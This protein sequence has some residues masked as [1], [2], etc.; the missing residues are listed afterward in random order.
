ML[1]LLPVGRFHFDNL[2]HG[3]FVNWRFSWTM[4]RSP[5]D[6]LLTP[7]CAFREGSLRPCCNRCPS[8]TCVGF[9][10]GKSQG[11][12]SCRIPCVSHAIFLSHPVVP[13]S[14]RIAL[15]PRSTMLRLH[16]PRCFVSTVHD[17]LSP[18][19]LILCLH[20]PRCFVSTVHD[21][22]SPHT[23]IRCLHTP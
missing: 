14:C 22:L 12:H 10:G 2:L 13:P 9:Y 17:T 18:H 4:T 6:N 3:R 20:S 23:L 1:L 16:G 7:T 5:E 8:G 21:T 15:S 11:I 19:T